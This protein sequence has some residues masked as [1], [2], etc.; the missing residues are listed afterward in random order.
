MVQRKRKLT[1]GGGVGNVCSA[2]GNRTRTGQHRDEAQA[3]ALEQTRADAA[4]LTMLLVSHFRGGGSVPA[5]SGARRIFCRHRQVAT[6]CFFCR[7]KKRGICAAYNSSCASCNNAMNIVFFACGDH[8]Q[9]SGQ[10]IRGV[11]Q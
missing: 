2:H 11:Y 1:G 5:E 6:G 3:K 9:R 4:Q 7:R 8:V 10:S